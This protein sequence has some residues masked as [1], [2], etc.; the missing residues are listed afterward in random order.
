[1]KI[2]LQQHGNTAVLVPHG[3]LIRDELEKFR[4]RAAGALRMHA[5][6]VVLDMSQVPFLDSG[7][8]EALLELFSAHPAAGGIELPPSMAGDE[9]RMANG[10]ERTQEPGGSDAMR[11]SPLAPRNSTAAGPRGGRLAALTETCREALDV[12]DSLTRL[13]VFDTVESALRSFL[14]RPSA[15]SRSPAVTRGE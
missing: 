9:S 2:D 3:P 5:G 6:R 15:Q 7:G 4:E 8:I 13:D 11:P 12:T 10:E 14:T 1:M